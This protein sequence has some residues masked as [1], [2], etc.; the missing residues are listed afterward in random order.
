MENT[1]SYASSSSYAGFFTRVKAY[2]IDAVILTAFGYTIGIIYNLATGGFDF[3]SLRIDVITGAPLIS[4]I[5][6]IVGFAYFAYYESSAKQATIGKQVMDI[7][8]VDMDGQRLSFG[9]AL[10]RVVLKIV[11]MIPLG[12]GFLLP[13]FTKQKQALHDLI[14]KTL[15]VKNY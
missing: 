7:K 1:I 12:I 10:L 8:V 2:L 9:K 4:I 13:F 5:N 14:G 11:S 3:S 15:V 6:F